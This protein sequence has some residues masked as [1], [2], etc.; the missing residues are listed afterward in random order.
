MLGGVGDPSYDHYHERHVFHAF[1]YKC[2]AIYLPQWL[3]KATVFRYPQ[4]DVVKAEGELHHA[5]IIEFKRVQGLEDQRLRQ[6]WSVSISTS[7]S[8]GYRN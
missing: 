4:Y 8:S 2:T 3:D 7:T 6:T 5:G 1:T